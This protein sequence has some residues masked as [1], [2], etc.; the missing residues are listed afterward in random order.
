MSLSDADQIVHARVEVGLSLEVQ[1]EVDEVPGEAVGTA[2][3]RFEAMRIEHARRAGETAQAA[4]AFRA[5]QVASGGGFH[6]Q[7]HR[8]S[9]QIRKGAA[10]IPQSE[11][12]VKSRPQSK[13]IPEPGSVEHS[14]PSP[15]VPPHRPMAGEGP[16]GSGQQRVR[17]SRGNHRVQVTLD[18]AANRSIHGL[19]PR[20]FEA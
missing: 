16:T 4:G 10:G 3:P 5:A 13:G 8:P 14:Q 2:E 6:A 1:V 19:G 9:T 18:P 11:G 17:G 12:R 7:A 20:K 15:T